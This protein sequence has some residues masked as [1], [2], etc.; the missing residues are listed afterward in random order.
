MFN[1]NFNRFEDEKV[2][3]IA[4]FIADK[5]VFL[6]IWNYVKEKVGNNEFQICGVCDI[7]NYNNL[8]IIYPIYL[9]SHRQKISGGC[10][11]WNS[12]D[13]F[14]KAFKFRDRM[15]CH[16]T[17]HRHLGRFGFSG[18]D[19]GE[20]GILRR[21]QKANIYSIDLV[22]NC[23]N[24]NLEIVDIEFSKWEG[25]KRFV[26]SQNYYFLKYE[27]NQSKCGSDEVSIF[28]DLR[29]QKEV[30]CILKILLSFETNYNYLRKGVINKKLF[31]H[32]LDFYLTGKEVKIDIN[33]DEFEEIIFF[34]EKEEKEKFWWRWYYD[35]GKNWD[36]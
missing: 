10:V 27:L 22:I 35:E 25:E 30:D 11:R 13:L 36:F 4:V 33:L 9:Y 20:R 32:L 29:L 14:E 18:I 2:N 24:N 34:W 1:Y 16:L 26:Y 7:V 31:Y 28:Y 8:T 3:K 23:D 15:V 12:Q 21:F 6:D 5:N 19:R 17:M